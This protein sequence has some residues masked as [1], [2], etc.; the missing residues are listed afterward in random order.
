MDDSPTHNGL[1][2]ALPPELPTLQNQPICRH[3]SSTCAANLSEGK[4]ALT[5][6]V[7]A[8]LSQHIKPTDRHWST[9]AAN[10][11]EEKM[12]LTFSV[13][14]ANHSQHIKPTDRHRS[15]CASNIFRSSNPSTQLIGTQVPVHPT[16]T[17]LPTLQPNR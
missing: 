3:T 14:A 10:I 7:L 17:G 9:C 5:Y 2:N 13:L 12:V 4:M 11:S 6:S 16:A 8:K 15:T 1:N